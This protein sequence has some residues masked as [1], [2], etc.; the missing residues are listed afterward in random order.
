MILA[1]RPIFP[2]APSRPLS[3]QAKGSYCGI[4][5]NGSTA[6]DRALSQLNRGKCAGLGLVFNAQI[7]PN[8]KLRLEL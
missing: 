5:S 4:R 7:E 8:T 3:G 2:R 1:P 6:C